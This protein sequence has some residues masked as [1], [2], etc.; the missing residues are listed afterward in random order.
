[1][2]K[3]RLRFESILVRKK[4]DAINKSIY[5]NSNKSMYAWYPA[6]VDD[7]ATNNL[8]RNQRI[9]APKFMRLGIRLNICI[10]TMSDHVTSFDFR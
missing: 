8:E 6:I 1:M 4:T 10:L 5:E 9:D 3:K 7:R 2:G